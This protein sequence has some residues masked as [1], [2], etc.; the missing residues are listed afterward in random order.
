MARR[1]NNRAKKLRRKKAT[2]KSGTRILSRRKTKMGTARK[3]KPI[4]KRTKPLA[5]KKKKARRVSFKVPKSYKVISVRGID[6]YEKAEKTIGEENIKAG[7]KRISE[8]RKI[9]PSK[10]GFVR[11]KKILRRVTKPEDFTKF[12]YNLRISFTGKSGKRVRIAKRGI[13]I[14][15]Y[16][17][18]S[19]SKINK[20]RERKRLPKLSKD[21]Y[22]EYVVYNR[23]RKL[24]FG[25]I[26]E[27]W[28]KY[29]S[30]TKKLQ[31]TELQVK[32]LMRSVRKQNARFSFILNREK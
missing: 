4:S 26:A 12:S 7:T 6:E 13:G 17:S 30:K 15:K 14:P 28:G 18:S 31:M 27:V 16:N 20:R 22:F 2:T 8:I 19:H 32:K 24:I 25:A 5:R 23:I 10:A 21:E 11:L 9:R 29:P 3:P 1:V